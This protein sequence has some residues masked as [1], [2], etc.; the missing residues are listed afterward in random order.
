MNDVIILHK[1]EKNISEEEFTPGKIANVTRFTGGKV[2]KHAVKSGLKNVSKKAAPS[3]FLKAGSKIITNPVFGLL[4][5]ILG[6]TAAATFFNSVTSIGKFSSG[7]E[8]VKS[9][10]FTDKLLTKIINSQKYGKN[11]FPTLEEVKSSSKAQNRSGFL[12]WLLGGGQ[13]AGE[14]VRD[15]A[16]TSKMYLTVVKG[17]PVSILAMSPIAGS[18]DIRQI[19]GT[20]VLIATVFVK[21]DNREIKSIPLCRGFL[22]SKFFG[23][24]Y[25]NKDAASLQKNSTESFVINR[26]EEC[27]LVFFEEGK[28]HPTII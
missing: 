5:S 27:A 23:K 24:N 28:E 13:A 7:E 6:S 20:R 16:G 9:P 26:S 4:T 14:K 8:M 11:G 18:M 3:V 25:V 21:N 19:D 17:V 12:A 2:L 15:L 10:Q 1:D 22:K